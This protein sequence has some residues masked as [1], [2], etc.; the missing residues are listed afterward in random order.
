MNLRTSQQERGQILVILV[1]A[2]VGL[3]AF[4]ALAIDVGMIFSDRRY[5]QN[6]AD[7]VAL[8][9]SAAVSKVTIEAYAAD[10]DKIMG[11]ETSLICLTTDELDPDRGSL[12]NPNK[13]PAE[14][15]YLPWFDIAAYNPPSNDWQD[16]WV[17]IAMH[18]AYEAAWARGNI[19][20]YDLPLVTTYA[21]FQSADEGIYIKCVESSDSNQ[22]GIF[23][24]AKV[25]SITQSSFAHFIFNGPLKNTVS[26][27]ARAL[28]YQK[29]FEGSSIVSLSQQCKNQIP[30]GATP[31]PTND[32]GTFLDGNHSI[33]L[34]GGGIY[35][36]SC[37]ERNGASGTV[38]IRDG[39]AYYYDDV[40]YNGSTT[41]PVDPDP[42]KFIPCAVHT[43]DLYPRIDQLVSCPS[44]PGVFN[45]YN[46]Q[47]GTYATDPHFTNVNDGSTITMA[48][49]LYC[50]KN[51][52]TVTGN[53]YTLIGAGVMI[54]VDS[55]SLRIEGG[56]TVRLTPPAES[57]PSPLIPGMSIL[58]P[59]TNTSPVTITGNSESYLEGTLY[60]PMSQVNIGGTSELCKDPGT[61]ESQCVIQII[62]DTIKLGG[63][64]NINIKYDNSKIA[65]FKPKVDLTK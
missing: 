59:S 9:G 10:P 23:T 32:G 50:F 39:L 60:A 36:N 5:D 35:S 14:Q 24:F 15:D 33:F 17:K 54:Y 13:I 44:T 1:L 46:M 29:P 52:F 42:L 62:G 43:T 55:G 61:G 45:G 41:C 22:K 3:L 6:V 28:P 53:N 47:P 2:L 38:V 48:S 57:A 40:T 8:A 21:D 65:T 63:T 37:I 19:N 18:D 31:S 56:G 11:T 4:T 26:A 12:Y 51:G 25:S 7:S 34:D 58:F 30:D 16:E 27:I 49:G 64:A 20:H